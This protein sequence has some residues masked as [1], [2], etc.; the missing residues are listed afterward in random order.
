VRIESNQCVKGD[1][2]FLP[3]G[4]LRDELLLVNFL[5]E[6]LRTDVVHVRGDTQ[7]RERF[8]NNRYRKLPGF[9]SCLR[10]ACYRCWHE[11]DANFSAARQFGS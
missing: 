7:R 4:R 2:K 8:S 9:S 10:D 11:M 3:V 5:D 6:V 1:R